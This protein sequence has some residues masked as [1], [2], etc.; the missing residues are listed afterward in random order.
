M[1]SVESTCIIEFMLT[2]QLPHGFMKSDGLDYVF[3]FFWPM[4]L[5]IEKGCFT[6]LKG[7]AAI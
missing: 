2:Y 4:Y 5:E 1:Q 7:E 3:S 6:C